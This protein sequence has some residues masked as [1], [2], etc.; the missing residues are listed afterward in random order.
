[1][2]RGSDCFTLA[3]QSIHSST[4]SSGSFLPDNLLVDRPDDMASRWSGVNPGSLSAFEG[5]D[6]ERRPWV[7]LEMKDFAILS[8]FRILMGVLR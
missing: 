4:A 1:M 5:I 3:I 7:L 8:K 6:G 2:H